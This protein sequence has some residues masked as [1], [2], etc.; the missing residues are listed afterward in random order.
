M[1][2]ISFLKRSFENPSIPLS[3]AATWGW[4]GS[5]NRSSSGELVNRDTA[6]AVP[7]VWACWRIL[8]ETIASLSWDVYVE[9]GDSIQKD[10][11]HPY[12]ALLKRNPSQ[13]YTSFTFRES[14]MLNALAHGV[15]YAYIRRDGNGQAVEL[16]VLDSREVTPVTMDN[17]TVYY[18]VNGIDRTI[19]AID[20]IA[21]PIMSF[22]GIDT[23]SV[24]A[25]AKQIIGEAL[26]AQRL[27]GD[28]YSNGAML[29]GVL[30]T[31]M[32]IPM[33]DKKKLKDKW[34]E[35]HGRGKR[36]GT[37]IL[38]HGLKYTPISNSM[39]EAQMLEMRSFY[40]QEVARI[41]NVPPHMIQELSRST[42]NNIEQ[43]SLDFAKYTIR[44]Y[45]KRIEEELNRK[46]FSVDPSRSVR[47]NMDSILRADIQSRAEYYQTMRMIGGMSQN[48]VRKM[49][50]LNPVEG[51]D[52]YTPM[53]LAQV[54]PNEGE[55]NV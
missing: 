25:G 33:A 43:Q 42:N 1:G 24:L 55:E 38:S 39:E 20:M 9:N 44:P 27:S 53:M 48:E 6:L 36:G 8:A 49:E 19:P 31:D 50:N 11:Q 18:R 54:N 22:D 47:F 16:I 12:S 41:Y 13:L 17:R 5:W 10:T 7:A 51:G 45:I 37:A 3:T 52:D 14:M 35:D 34:N 2:L 30:S 23:N 15:M 32:E 46:L 21:V 29:T 4:L 26:A 40:V 28:Y